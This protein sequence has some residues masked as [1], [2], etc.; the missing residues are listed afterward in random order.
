MPQE[1]CSEAAKFYYSQEKRDESSGTG[2]VVA[3]L[4]N[5]CRQGRTEISRDELI[6]IVATAHPEIATIKD[7]TIRTMDHPLHLAVA[8][9]IHRRIVTR[10]AVYGS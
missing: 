10:L 8:D 1:Y 4:E 3:E 7:R 9:E 6:Q 2:V 5:L